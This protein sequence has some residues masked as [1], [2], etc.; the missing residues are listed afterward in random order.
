LKKYSPG[1]EEMDKKRSSKASKVYLFVAYFTLNSN[2]IPI[3]D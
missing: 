3:S 2:P 1:F